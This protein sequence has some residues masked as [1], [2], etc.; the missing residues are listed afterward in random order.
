MKRTVK[1]NI[2]KYGLSVSGI[3]YYSKEGS[4]RGA[5]RITRTVSHQFKEEEFFDEVFVEQNKSVLYVHRKG[6]V[7]P[8]TLE[9]FKI[10]DFNK[11][12]AIPFIK[13]NCYLSHDH[14]NPITLEFIVRNF[15]RD[16]L[17]LFFIKLD[18]QLVT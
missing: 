17:Q 3:V 15:P 9:D 14:I 4:Q 13:Q 6:I 10:L 8:I 11:E 5:T 12:E 16:F 7:I 2:K 18:F 1:R